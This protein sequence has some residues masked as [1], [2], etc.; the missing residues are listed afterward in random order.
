MIEAEPASLILAVAV[1][2][3]R[4]G[5]L[6]LIAPGLSSTNAP[7][8]IRLFIALGLSLAVAPLI[9]PEAQASVI[10]ARPADLLL[11]LGSETLIGLLLGFLSRLLLMALQTL[12]VGIANAIGLGGI[13]GAGYEP[14]ESGQPAATLFTVTAVTIIFVADLHYE[15]LRA[16]VGSYAVITPGG[17]L[18]PQAALVAVSDRFAAAFLVALRL[19]APFLIYSVIV[20]FAVGLTNKLT[21][22]L[23][24][25]FVSV[26]FVAAGG[27]L[28]LALAIREVMIAF[29]DAFSQLS[30]A[31]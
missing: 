27:L 24:V 28:M 29:M 5:G 18:D 15:I 23:P 7:V 8:H 12:A 10:D 30:A 16:V 4:V 11:T 17:A 1:V 9:L 3:A 21:P 26:P 6:F 22:S 20:N 13:P 25:Y 19:A 2:F 14:G 31:L